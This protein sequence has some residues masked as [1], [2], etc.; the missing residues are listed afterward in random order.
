[1]ETNK[2][3]RSI[4][5]VKSR[6]RPFWGIVAA[7]CS[8][9]A[10]AEITQIYPSDEG[11]DTSVYLKVTPAPK[12][13]DTSNVFHAFTKPV[14][15]MQ[16]N[17][18]VDVLAKDM[19]NFFSEKLKSKLP[20]N[21]NAEG[22]DLV[23]RAAVNRKLLAENKIPADNAEGYVLK[24]GRLKD[25]IEAQVTGGSPRGVQHGLQSLRQ[26]LISW[27][28][29][30]II[31]LTDIAD[32]PTYD[33]R[34]VKRQSPY[35]I[36]MAAKYKMNGATVQSSIDYNGDFKEY[37]KGL[38]AAQV[39]IRK[40]LLD[41]LIMVNMGNYISGD[42]DWEAKVLEHYANLAKFGYNYIAVMYDDKM[43]YLN[44][45]GE[46]RFGDYAGAQVYYVNKIYDM[47]K[48]DP[49]NIK[50]GFMPN[51][52]Y[53]DDIDENYVRQIKGRV[54]SDVA[55]FWAGKGCPGK[56]ID[57]AYVNEVLKLYGFE[58]MW[59][60]MNWPQCGNPYYTE[61]Y[62]PLVNHDMGNP[63]I[64]KLVTVSTTT[65]QMA[66]PTSFITVC[67]Y[68][69]NPEAYNPETSFRLAVKEMVP[70]EAYRAFYDLL[71]Y[72]SDSS[73]FVKLS[74]KNPMYSA[75]TAEERRKLLIDRCDE[76]DRLAAACEAT[77]FSKEPAII[78]CLAEV[79]GRKGDYLKMLKE[80]EDGYFAEIAKKT[81]ECPKL[82]APPKIDGN[83][84]DP[85]WTG[86]AAGGGFTT[87]N[88]KLEAPYQTDFKV[89]RTD[90]AI[91]L[92]IRCQEPSIEKLIN[93]DNDEYPRPLFKKYDAFLWWYDEIEVFFDP[94]H[95]CR[96][97]YQI[98]INPLGMKEAFKYDS[99]KYGYFNKT[100][101]SR[102]YPDISG[103]VNRT[104]DS[105]AVELEIPFAVFGAAGNAEDW[106]F[107]I[108]RT[109]TVDK[110]MK[111]TLWSPLTWGF[112]EAAN[113]GTIKMGKDKE[114]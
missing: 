84:D 48:K 62:G 7:V 66:L 99:L 16:D 51:F 65:Y 42:G 67:D 52:Y 54:N 86:A 113:F 3:I 15:I 19:Q 112:Q 73:G 92:A 75:E 71:K 36:A 102:I 81:V 76:I 61:N 59:H 109:R 38:A 21:E 77:E 60:Y 93:L 68:L 87:I 108:G 98:I 26:L 10:C 94:G 50:M 64:M 103:A 30:T 35:W 69:W 107:E 57:A 106:G 85:A 90:K 2:N 80:L 18:G 11:L 17:A 25:C 74:E 91:Y 12:H 27:K 63:D 14:L 58:K 45:S 56:D 39:N 100:N 72:L 28:G 32:W 4:Y 37:E 33:A 111:Y 89:F 29:R 82:P 31:K 44:K 6:M 34:F 9:S 23:I 114:R 55:L 8:F 97:V 104:K 41:S 5:S 13:E 105:W 47:L 1:M 20:V 88:G 22:K 49:A 96:D 101:T 46:K 83:I 43:T 53:G 110:K 24:I 70:P 78:K 95:D 40:G 79:K